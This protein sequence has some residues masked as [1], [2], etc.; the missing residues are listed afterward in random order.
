M[1]CETANRISI[2]DWLNKE[3]YSYDPHR[4][5]NNECWYC[6][7]FRDERTPSFKVDNY[8]NRWKDFGTGEGGSLIDLVCKM[9]NTDTSGALTIL[10]GNSGIKTFKKV[11]RSTEPANSKPGVIVENY[12]LLRNYA[13]ID[14]AK[15]R[16]IYNTYTQNY[17]Y[18]AEYT[19]VKSG[20]KYYS[21]AFK[22]DKGG[23][24]LRNKYQKIATSPKSITTINPGNKKLLLFEGFI[25]Y[26][27]AL[28]YFSRK[29]FNATVI[30]L[31]SV[32][33]V[34]HIIGLVK[35]YSEI[36]FFLDNDRA[37]KSAV[38][39]ISNENRNVTNWAKKIYPGF[40][41]FNEFITSEV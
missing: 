10:A 34:M 39:K 4:S 14:Y 32:S 18:E 29:K 8:R 5:K 15:K 17:L 13:L 24:E 36:H 11:L 37:G 21:L 3:G 23:Y 27:S 16:N 1:N 38:E 30:V 9:Y 33:N 20:K 31:N 41:D 19:I 22:N 35:D 7:P 6:S 25:D 40:N 12:R 26:L 28:T 2:V